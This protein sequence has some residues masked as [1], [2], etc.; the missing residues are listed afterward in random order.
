LAEDVSGKLR[1]GDGVVRRSEDKGD[2]MLEVSRDELR[3]VIE[4][5]LCQEDW[6]LA[7]RQGKGTV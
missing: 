3:E 1:G 6:E 2:D 7:L 5:E 4:R